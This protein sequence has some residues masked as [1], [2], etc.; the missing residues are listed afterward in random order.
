MSKGQALVNKVKRRAK[1]VVEAK[2]AQY[3]VDKREELLQSSPR[4]LVT[5][6]KPQRTM[7]ASFG[8]DAVGD[9]PHLEYKI[10]ATSLIRFDFGVSDF[11]LKLTLPAITGITNTIGLVVGDLV[12]IENQGSQVEARMLQIVSMAANVIRL[13]DVATYAGTENNVAVRFVMSGVTRSYV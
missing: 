13:D 7:D 11:G 8:K 12:V 6:R 9:K 1:S 2:K 5:V 10:V 3:K 4:A